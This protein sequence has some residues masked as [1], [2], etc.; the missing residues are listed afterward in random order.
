[1]GAPKLGTDP[2]NFEGKGGLLHKV[3][4]LLQLDPE[5]GGVHITLTPCVPRYR[6]HPS[7]GE[8]VA[9]FADSW[10]SEKFIGWGKGPEMHAS[11]CNE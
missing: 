11:K 10:P 8:R 7:K 3:C 5:A 9:I 6:R 1:M 2:S 4:T